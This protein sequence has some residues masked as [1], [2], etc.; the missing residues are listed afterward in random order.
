MGEKRGQRK[1]DSTGDKK[2]MDVRKG[3]LLIR[4]EVWKSKEEKRK[5]TDLGMT[6]SSIHTVNRNDFV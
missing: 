3:A 6:V 4:N 1:G 2:G 5:N